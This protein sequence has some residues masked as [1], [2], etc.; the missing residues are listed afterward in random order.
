MLFLDR[1]SR[2]DVVLVTFSER[3]HTYCCI[4]IKNFY[5]HMN[6]KVQFANENFVITSFANACVALIS[7]HGQSVSFTSLFAKMVVIAKRFSSVFN[8]HPLIPIYKLNC[9]MEFASL[10]LPSKECTTP[11]VNSFLCFIRI[12]MKSSLALRQCRN[13][14][15][16]NVEH[17][18]CSSKYFFWVSLGQKFNLS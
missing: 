7:Q 11:A 3:L 5:L 4:T 13:I 2:I 1:I 17:N 18:N 8:E 6:H 10:G 14:S 9:S 12:Y 15:S 16:I